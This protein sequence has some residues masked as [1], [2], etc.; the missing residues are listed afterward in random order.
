MLTLRH[1]L[2]GFAVESLLAALAAAT[3]TLA[4]ALFAERRLGGVG[5][6]IP[7]ILV[8][9]VLLIR[10][11]VAAVATA[12]ALP[13]LCEGSTFGIPVMTRLYDHVYK[14]LTAL[15]VLVLPAGV[16]AALDLIRRRRQPH[17]PP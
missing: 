3:A 4:V 9:V 5:L 11:P 17:L 14:Q 16:A 2:H 7:L 12:V 15:D 6:F 8:A 1:R 13:I 10:R